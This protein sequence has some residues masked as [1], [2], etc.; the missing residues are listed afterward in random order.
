M[1]PWLVLF[2]SVATG[3][4]VQPLVIRW[5]KS[6]G[7]LDVPNERSSHV[8]ITPRGG[9]IAVV[10][11]LG[12][13]LL[14]GH[15]AGRD[16]AVVLLGATILGAVGLTDDLRGLNASARLAILL[17]VGALAGLLLGSPIP[18]I[19]AVPAMAVWIT[20]YVNAFN[21]MDGINGV[22]GMTGI[23]AGVSYALM[24]NAFH[25]E[26]AVVTGA[27]LAGGSAAF[28][29]YNYPLAKVFLGD[30]GSYSIGFTIA[31]LGWVVW[32]AGAPLLLALAPT[33]VYMADTGSTLVQRFR[34][35][36]P[37][38]D[39]HREHT[40]QRLV[41]AGKSHTLVA[42]LVAGFQVLTVLFVQIGESAGFYALGVLLGSLVVVSYL[43]SPQVL[44]KF[45]AAG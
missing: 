20:A 15:E 2:V 8:S 13:G 25:S 28:L 42:L 12:A 10:L 9:G 33:A 4:L 38:M 31:A 44:R 39:A 6:H 27:A 26:V 16:V 17:I 41:L 35:G 23:V 45:D 14:L 32:A 43:A 11:S 29:P 24:G 34:R 18:L 7:V 5:L 22:S 19:I 1:T 40:Y 30:V 36:S 3:F 37:L 21:F